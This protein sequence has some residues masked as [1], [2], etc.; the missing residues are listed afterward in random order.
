MDLVLAR[1]FTVAHSP[2]TVVEFGY[3]PFVGMYRDQICAL[4]LDVC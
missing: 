1:M 2:A 3:A 4:T